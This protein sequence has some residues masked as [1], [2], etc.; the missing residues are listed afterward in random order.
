MILTVT[1]NTA[2]DHTIMVPAFRLGQTIRATQAFL[3]PGGKG[4]DVSFIL[5]TLGVPTRAQGFAA[6]TYGRKIEE[7]LRGRGAETDFVWVDGETRL[8]TIVVCSDGSG[9][10]TFTVDTLAPTAQD[11]D[12]LLERYEDS[13]PSAAA[14]VVGGSPPRTV[15]VETLGELVAR[16][17]RRGLPVLLDASGEALRAAVEAGPTLLKP[18]DVEL[19]Q[20]IGE[21][22]RGLAAVRRAAETVQDRYGCSVVVTLGSEGGL[23][24]TPDGAWRVEP[25][26]L[27]VVSTAGAGDAVSAGL[28]RGLA[29]GWPFEHS[30]R[31]GFAAA[32]AVVLTPVTADCRPEDVERLGP[33]M[34]ITPLA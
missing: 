6:G 24:V 11:L 17:R 22:V 19:G 25:P 12:R 26:P 16:A 4:T 3:G 20:L 10:A 5:G 7:L 21:P 27:E 9:S 28:V 33:Q 31:L 2:I 23:A 29:E 18:N 34:R 8:N 1:L 14:V 15:P 30:L 32:S 13:L